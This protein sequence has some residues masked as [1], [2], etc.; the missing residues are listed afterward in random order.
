MVKGIIILSIIAI[1]CD[2]YYEVKYPFISYVDIKSSKALPEGG[3]KIL[4]ISDYHDFKLS[5]NLYNKI[6]GA[7]RESKPDVIAITGDLVDESTRNLDN[8]FEFVEEIVELNPNVY[9]VRGNHEWVNDRLKQL[10]AGL[11]KRKVTVLNDANKAIEIRGVK[12][13]I[14]GIDDVYTRHGDINKALKGI[15]KDLYTIMLS[16]SPDIVRMQKD[17]LADLILSGHTHGGQVRLPF[18]GAV[19]APG[20]GL[21]PKYS[22]GL[23]TINE[24]TTLY[25]DSG[26]GT[27]K[28]PLDRKSVV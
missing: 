3:I 5:N 28:L 21:F 12:V 25:I 14:C 17:I 24:N 9:F 1:I 7:I 20:Q 11:L 23:Y 27:S 10:L 8:V 19:I 13:N 18:I 4:H 2:I 6:K 16:H 15:E 22:K 26:L